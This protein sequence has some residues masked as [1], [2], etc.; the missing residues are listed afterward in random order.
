MKHHYSLMAGKHFSFVC[1]LITNL[2]SSKFKELDV[3]RRPL[4]AN[5]V[6]YKIELVA[7]SVFKFFVLQVNRYIITPNLL[8]INLISST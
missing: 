1:I 6:T 8:M 5:T 4:F 2:W 7:L 3:C